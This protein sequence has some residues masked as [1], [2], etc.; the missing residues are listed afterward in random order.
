M[1]QAINKATYAY[2]AELEKIQCNTET[3]TQFTI[4]EEFI[5]MVNDSAEAMIEELVGDE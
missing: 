3:D 5:E 1:I 4:I 2:F